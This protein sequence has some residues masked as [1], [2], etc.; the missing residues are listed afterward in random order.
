MRLKLLHF[1]LVIV[2][3][4]INF[5]CKSGNT[6][7]A[8]TANSDTAV[9]K[10]DSTDEEV[11][12]GGFIGIK[13]HSMM[14]KNN[15]DLKG[16]PDFDFASLMQI[17]HKNGLAIA[18]EEIKYGSDTTMRNLAEKIKEGQENDLKELQ[19]FMDTN[20]PGQTNDSFLKE[21]KANL[22]KTKDETEKSSGMSGNFDKDFANLMLLH[23]RQGL[24]IAKIEIKYGKNPDM[25]K[26]AQ[27]IVK[28]QD[29]EMKQLEAYK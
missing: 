3:V 24:D 26:L 19:N 22:Q 11:I 14:Q 16:D 9:L 18:N 17:H 21:I 4:T 7:N 20:N 27:N 12:S 23:H 28:H 10:S 29:D 8:D 1:I 25:K 2:I 6:N 5:S 13:N 15:L